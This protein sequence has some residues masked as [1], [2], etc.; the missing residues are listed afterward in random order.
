MYHH[1]YETVQA[2]HLQKS[3]CKLIAADFEAAALDVGNA[4]HMAISLH[5]VFGKETSNLLLAE[6][7][8]FQ[9]DLDKAG[10]LFDD[11][12]STYATAGFQGLS[13]WAML[14]NALVKF[15][16]SLDEGYHCLE[17][18]SLLLEISDDGRLE[19][20]DCPTVPGDRKSVV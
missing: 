18:S 13:H 20:R 5:D 7:Y 10:A 6:I 17:E 8:F 4:L 3:I 16:L 14:E 11:L 1:E 9:G 19:V 12:S 15:N 2:G